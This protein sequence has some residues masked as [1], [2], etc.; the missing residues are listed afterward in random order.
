MKTQKAFVI[1]LL[2]FYVLNTPFFT[3][4][5]SNAF[6]EEISLNPE[7]TITKSFSI[8]SLL[9]YDFK[10]TPFSTGQPKYNLTIFNN[11]NTLT[12]QPLLDGEF[13]I[14]FL[15]NGTYYYKIS[16]LSNDSLSLRL[17]VTTT[18]VYKEKEQDMYSLAFSD[19]ILWYVTLPPNQT[20]EYSLTA[21][22][23]GKYYLTANVL[24]SSSSSSVFLYISPLATSNQS[25]PTVARQLEIQFYLEKSIE[26]TSED[27]WIITKSQSNETVN[28][29]FV[30]SNE[31]T[32]SFS[33]RD[34]AIV[35]VIFTML[36]LLLRMNT[37]KKKKRTNRRVYGTITAEEVKKQSVLSATSV[38]SR[39]FPNM[40]Y[41]SPI[42]NKYRKEKKQ[43]EEANK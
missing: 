5:T 30:L 28:L 9:L 12:M 20:K 34:I 33:I 19:D 24:S 7:E 38:D 2:L 35:V 18:Y 17:F 4:S 39:V 23:E 32:S 31:N 10:L 13:K 1:V 11:T 8:D 21:V 14:M 36:L 29:V 16:N 25:W 6:E 15:A 3:Y 22:K 41:T 43:E 27:K 42:V 26:I 40:P 37:E